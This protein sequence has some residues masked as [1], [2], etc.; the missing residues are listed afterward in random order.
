MFVK[1]YRH[2]SYTF[3]ENNS[4]WIKD[5]LIKCKIINLLE[6]NIGQNLHNF[7]LHDTSGQAMK[8]ELIHLNYIKLKTSALKI[9]LLKTSHR[10][11]K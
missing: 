1:I 3:T 5:L 2:R 9:I 7:W 6:E 4:K 8:N 11:K 10:L